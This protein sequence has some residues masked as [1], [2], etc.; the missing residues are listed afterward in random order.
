M[1]IYLNT[2]DKLSSKICIHIHKLRDEA[3][4]SAPLTMFADA[5]Y[6]LSCCH[7]HQLLAD[8]FRKIESDRLKILNTYCELRSNVGCS[9]LCHALNCD[10]QSFCTNVSSTY[11]IAT[12]DKDAAFIKFH[13]IMDDVLVD[14]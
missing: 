8:W 11:V 1:Q 6:Q 4:A 10:I 3:S 9:G 7:S 5:L 12:A 13:W 14:D 2:F